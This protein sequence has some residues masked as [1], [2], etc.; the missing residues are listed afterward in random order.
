MRTIR[1]YSTSLGSGI[2]EVQVEDNC[3]WEQLKQKIG[4]SGENWTGIGRP[5]KTTYV[6]VVNANSNPELSSSLNKDDVQINIFPK[7]MKAGSIY[8]IEDKLR[9]MQ[10]LTDSLNNLIEEIF[11]DL[12][13]LKDTNNLTNSNTNK[14]SMQDDTCNFASGLG[15]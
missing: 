10:D 8:N 14:S 3:T 12:E 11:N 2:K 7:Q 9:D 6:S 13:K 1:I 5:T 15:L 4:I